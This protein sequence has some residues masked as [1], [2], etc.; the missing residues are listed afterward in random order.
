[1]MWACAAVTAVLFV[2]LF[3][4]FIWRMTL[5]ATSRWGG[6]WSHA[7]VIPAISLWFLWQDREHLTAM[8]WKP[9]AW[10]LIPLLAGILSYAWW[11]YP[12]R[13]DMFQGYSMILALLGLVWMIFGSAMLRRLWIPILYLAFAVKVSDRIW[14][15]IAWKLQLLAAQCATFAIN[16]VGAIPSLGLE[17]NVKGS[18][19][20]LT[21]MRDGGWV[22]EALNVAEACSGLRMLAAFMALGV[23]VACMGHRKAWQRLIMV[24][25]TVP[26]AVLVNVGRVTVLGVLHRIN[27]QLA[28]GD[29]H[30]FIGMLMLI[31]ALLLFLA[32]GWVLE[33]IIIEDASAKVEKTSATVSRLDGEDSAI[34]RPA[35]VGAGLVAGGAMT[36]ALGATW[37]LALSC[38][39]PDLWFG[40]VKPALVWG[41]T[42]VSLLALIVGVTWVARLLS[43]GAAGAT[44][45]ATTV[46][47]L[48]VACVGLQSAV[49]GMKAV[50]IKKPVPLREPLLLIPEKMGPWKMEEDQRFSREI[51][52]E[53]R[54]ENYL[55]RTYRD[56]SAAQAEPGSMV[57]LHVAYYTGTPDTVPHV[58]ERCYVA[59]GLVQVSKTTTELELQTPDMRQTD[60]GYV[61]MSHLS[62]QARTVRM[63]TNRWSATAFT[64]AAPQRL[65]RASNVIYFFVANGR[66]LATPDLVR[67]QGFDLKDAYSYYCKVEVGIPGVGDREQAVR[68][69][70]RFLASVMPEIMG[71][72]PDWV[73]VTE[74]RWPRDARSAP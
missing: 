70:Q 35:R 47:I 2:L 4:N 33:R 28:A 9:A 26:I 16:I 56:T 41:M 36:L 20:E 63:P 54:T 60:G 71:C 40:D 49:G 55:S 34:A 65:E 7:V 57:R 39:R 68:I 43:R 51:L 37:G 52:E 32:V 69:A 15:Q 18:T 48:L 50:L 61:A 29:V 72:L 45:L 1:M 38:A 24:L 19:I 11:I 66:F 27:P 59:G 12:G 67:L 58:P 14:E 62:S 64:F 25:L 22:T 73:D 42:L 23:A 13:N 44:A 31:P 30:L 53:L 17:A 3:H 6:D 21:F 74:G 8:T 10:G 46:G 5:I